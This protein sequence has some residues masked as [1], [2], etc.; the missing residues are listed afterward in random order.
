[1]LIKQMIGNPRKILLYSVIIL[2]ITA[3]SG[4]RSLQNIFLPETIREK[5]ERFKY[6]SVF[7]G[8]LKGVIHYAK[9]QCR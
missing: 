9:N 8:I 3:K 4:I 7:N 2:T 1:M 5:N 6:A